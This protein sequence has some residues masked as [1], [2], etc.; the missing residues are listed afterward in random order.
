M[1]KNKQRSERMVKKLLKNREDDRVRKHVEPITETTNPRPGRSNPT[2]LKREQRG[3]EVDY[4]PGPGA[5]MAPERLEPEECP[6]KVEPAPLDMQNANMVARERLERQISDLMDK[7]NQAVKERNFL[8]KDA[9]DVLDLARTAAYTHPMGEVS[10]N[11]HE[12]ARR[13]SELEPQFSNTANRLG[14]LAMEIRQ[15][16][17]AREN[18]GG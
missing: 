10:V 16:E 2:I 18:Q 13:L 1:D 9:L 5:I 7:V 17:Q 4:T 15:S 3:M 8:I 12:A 6:D 11:I 14:N